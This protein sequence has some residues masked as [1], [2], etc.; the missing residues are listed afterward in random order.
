[1]GRIIQLLFIVSAISVPAGQLRAAPAQGGL[2]GLFEGYY[3]DYAKG[4]RNMDQTRW[5]KYLTPDFVMV[6]PDGK[7]HT[8]PEMKKYV[9]IN[10]RTTKRVISYSNSIEALTQVS[11]TK[12][13]AIILQKY[14]RVQAPAEDPTEGHEIRTSVVQREWWRRTPR[15]WRQY[16]VE[17]LLT[18]PSYLDGKVME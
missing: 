11:P 7:T 3:A 10:A 15:G 12:V 13:A 17:E 14:V 16:R 8:A 18:G 5:Q 6:S 1:M 2:R 4:V 9:E